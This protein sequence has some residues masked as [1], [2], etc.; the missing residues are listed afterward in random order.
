MSRYNKNKIQADGSGKDEN[1]H[2][3]LDADELLDALE[4]LQLDFELSDDEEDEKEEDNKALS[5][6]DLEA[7]QQRREK[8]RTQKLLFLQN[9]LMHY[10]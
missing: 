3:A 7:R 2:E 9:L 5:A 4:D 10:L 8:V 1:G 6:K